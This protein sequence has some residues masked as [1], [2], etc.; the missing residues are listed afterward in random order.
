M[1]NENTATL[2]AEIR[3]NASLKDILIVLN[4][5]SR[6]GLLPFLSSLP[7]YVLRYSEL[8]ANKF[9]NR[10]NKLYNTALLTRCYV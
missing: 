9:Y 6:P 4:N 8:V 7:I 1:V 10:A 5:H 2:I 3:I